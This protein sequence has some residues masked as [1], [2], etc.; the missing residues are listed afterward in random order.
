MGNEMKNVARG[1]KFLWATFSETMGNVFSRHGQCFL[2]LSVGC[3]LVVRGLSVGCAYR[4]HP[5]LCADRRAAVRIRVYQDV[6]LCPCG[7]RP[8]I[9]YSL[10]LTQYAHVPTAVIGCPAG[11]SPA[12]HGC[13]FLLSLRVIQCLISSLMGLSCRD[14]CLLQGS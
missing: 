8:A 6:R 9:S 4:L 7:H 2:L 12:G 10:Y 13:F 11:S 3:P 14:L 1:F 5:R